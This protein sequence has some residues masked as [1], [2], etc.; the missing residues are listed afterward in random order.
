MTDQAIVKVTEG[1]RTRLEQAVGSNN[2]YVGPPMAAEVGERL[3][4]LFLFHIVPNR[5]MRNQPRYSQPS[6]SQPP[7]QPSQLL[8]A[9]PLD[10]RY[11]ITVFR[12][13]GAAGL[14]EPNELLT[15]GQ[16]FR[17]L[18]ANPTLSGAALQEQ[19]VRLTL[20]PY[21]MEEL[22]RVW[23]LFPQDHYRTSVV[24]LASPV[25]V[26]AGIEA[27]GPPVITKEQKGGSFA[28]PPDISGRKGEQNAL[29][30]ISGG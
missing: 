8:D 18:Q 10:L 5:E 9:L 15:L 1:I 25:F 27:A 7:Q 23:G 29:G 2:V 16:I 17:V 24:Y 11:L 26:E 22:S 3:V 13:A 20:D 21:P 4:S 6:Q 19:L 30:G 12:R 14:A 28:E